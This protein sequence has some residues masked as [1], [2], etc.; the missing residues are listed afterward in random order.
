MSVFSGPLKWKRKPIWEWHIKHFSTK[1]LFSQPISFLVTPYRF[2]LKLV[3]EGLLSILLRWRHVLSF[4]LV[5]FSVFGLSV[6]HVH[7]Y[8]TLT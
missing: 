4:E 3:I 1:N 5:C 8:E 2:E 6:F 7:F